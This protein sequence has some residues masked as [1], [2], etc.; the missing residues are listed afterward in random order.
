MAK[1]TA[2]HEFAQKDEISKEVKADNREIKGSK[3]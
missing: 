3:I 2:A 1:Y